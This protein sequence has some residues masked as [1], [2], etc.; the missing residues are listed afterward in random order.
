MNQNNYYLA[1]VTGKDVDIV[2]GPADIAYIDAITVHQ[3]EKQTKQLLKEANHQFIPE[4]SEFVIFQAI[5][6][7]NQQEYIKIINPIFVSEKKEKTPHE[8]RLEA[9]FPQLVQERINNFNFTHQFGTVEKAKVITYTDENNASKKYDFKE[10]VDSIVD[11]LF[12]NNTN[13]NNFLSQM[14]G[15]LP[16]YISNIFYQDKYLNEYQ[17]RM[18]Y[19]YLKNYKT[20]RVFYSHYLYILNPEL[21]KKHENNNQYWRSIK[22]E[23]LIFKKDPEKY[24]RLREE[25]EPNQQ[26]T[27]EEYAKQQEEQAA[28]DA[29]YEELEA[30]NE[31]NRVAISELERQYKN[32]EISWEELQERSEAYKKSYGIELNR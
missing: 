13:K 6:Q 29:Y 2:C 31:A 19:D 9:L 16:K 10:F 5:A 7:N 18:I 8:I 21:K 27:L 25:N 4:D 17:K 22:R 28:W 24:Y 14:N 32:G 26:I 20:I 3:T 15:Y 12:S 23:F 30:E 11:N 1:I